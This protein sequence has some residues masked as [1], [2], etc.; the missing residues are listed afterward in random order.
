MFESLQVQNSTF[1]KNQEQPPTGNESDRYQR[2]Q[3]EVYG[4][5]NQD[6]RQQ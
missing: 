3:R 1:L 4:I 5:L 2:L 6:N